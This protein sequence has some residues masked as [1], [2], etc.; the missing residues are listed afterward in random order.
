MNIISRRLWFFLI[1]GVLVLI[2]IGSLIAFGLKP[3]IEFTSGFEM[4]IDSSNPID[5]S[6]LTQELTK[7]GYQ[8][9]I[10][11]SSGA[12]E[13]LVQTHQL[14]TAESDQLVSSIKSTFDGS[15]VQTDNVLPTVSNETKRNTAIAVVIAIAGMLLYIVWAFHKMP[16]PIRYGACAVAGLLFDVCLALGIYSILGHFLGWEINLMFVVGALTVIGVS[17]NNTVI[18]FDRVRE[19]WKKG[20][21]AD[22]EVVANASV[23]ETLTRSINTSLTMLFALFVLLLFVGTPIRNF[24][25][26]MIIGVISGTFTS[27]CISPD[28]LV[29]WQKKDWG[30][31]SPKTN[32]D[33]TAK[34]RSVVS[35]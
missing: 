30:A 14:S 20:F 18:V 5:Q 24:A 3:G 2:S 12:N 8:D 13:Y 31:F 32:T 34:A 26:V 15:Q 4:T 17:V 29:A 10:I 6:A 28:L 16:N 25:V 33:L 23:V 9:A 21:S 35:E 11:R 19:N 7:L 22:V 1:A 27:T